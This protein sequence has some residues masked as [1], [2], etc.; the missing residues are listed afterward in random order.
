[1]VHGYFP[2]GKCVS[3]CILFFFM[4]IAIHRNCNYD[5]DGGDDD[6]NDD[7]DD[8]DDDYSGGG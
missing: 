3:S 6:D 1:M 2:L 5:G 7:D 8:D 4:P